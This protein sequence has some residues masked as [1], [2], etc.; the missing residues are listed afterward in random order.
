MSR[1]LGQVR[2]NEC[3][4]NHEHIV[5]DEE[6]RPVT[7]A[8]I[9]GHF[10]ASG[11]YAGL[12]VAH[13]H[14]VLCHALYLAWVDWPPTSEPRSGEKRGGSLAP[15]GTHWKLA[16]HPGQRFT[17]L[18]YRHS[19]ND[20]PGLLDAPVFEVEAVVTYRR[21]PLLLHGYHI[22]RTPEELRGYVDRWNATINNGKT[23]A[24]EIGS[25]RAMDTVSS[26][27]EVAN[28]VPRG[29][30]GA[31]TVK[32]MYQEGTGP[33]RLFLGEYGVA[34]WPSGPAAEDPRSYAEEVAR[35]VRI[36]LADRLHGPCLDRG[37]PGEPVEDPIAPIAASVFLEWKQKH[38]QELA[39]W[40][41]LHAEQCKW[42]RVL[43]AM[44]ERIDADLTAAGEP[45]ACDGVVRGHDVR[46]DAL[47]R[48]ANAVVHK[49]AGLLFDAWNESVAQRSA[50]A[51]SDS[52]N[53]RRIDGP[54]H[55]CRAT[56]D[57]D[58]AVGIVFYDLRCAGC[59]RMR[60]DLDGP[61][62]PVFSRA[63]TARPVDE[64]GDELDPDARD[65]TFSYAEI[66]ATRRETIER[67]ALAIN[68]MQGEATAVGDAERALTLNEAQGRVR[69]LDEKD[70]GE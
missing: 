28:V 53:V 37:M 44:V 39:E 64:D 59:L 31:V 4:G 47:A 67:C 38:S 7:E 9:G 36:A 57:A 13:A 23:I 63:E 6:P 11:D 51:A 41:R 8:D 20:E 50:K 35:C 40:A 12:I 27:P 58:I 25:E 17:D 15:S 61:L 18:S 30:A 16:S 22:G 24:D 46:I 5:L 62:L 52:D 42:N 70:G 54:G 2:C 26:S 65:C 48:R 69:A 3:P 56:S 68:D 10:W 14:C 21:R 43:T 45:P 55:T 29:I 66:Q 1:N 34:T 49:H 32:D 33:W 60:I 19:F